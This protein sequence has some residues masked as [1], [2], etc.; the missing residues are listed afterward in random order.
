[1]SD[2]QVRL[3]DRIG[4]EVDGSSLRRLSSLLDEL[5]PAD[6]EHATVSRTDSD[7]WNLEF[8]ADS[9]LFENVDVSGG[10]VGTLPLSSREEGLS[11]AEEFIRGDFEALRSRPWSSRP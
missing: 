11:I 10:E 7:E 1:M 3:T 9:V 4:A 8:S 6:E 5:T 2:R